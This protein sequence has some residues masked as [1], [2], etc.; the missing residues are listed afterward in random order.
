MVPFKKEKVPKSQINLGGGPN[1]LRYLSKESTPSREKASGGTE[2]LPSTKYQEASFLKQHHTLCSNES[3]NIDNRN[4]KTNQIFRH[5]ILPTHRLTN[6][7]VF[8]VEV[9]N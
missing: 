4:F 1:S 6:K 8:N 2:T 3:P 5:R 9:P 7:H